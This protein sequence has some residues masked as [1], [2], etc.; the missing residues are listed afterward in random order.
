MPVISRNSVIPCQ[1]EVTLETT[2]N[3][4]GEL[5]LIVIQGESRL[6]QE[7]CLVGQLVVQNLRPGKAGSV[8]VS[9]QYKVN[10]DGILSVVAIEQ[11][12]PSNSESLNINSGRWNLTDNIVQQRRSSVQL[13][14]HHWET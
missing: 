11:G 2:R 3:N 7:N 5:T 9:C 6:A 1:A 14:Q 12:N 10:S 4:Q 8:K 13:L